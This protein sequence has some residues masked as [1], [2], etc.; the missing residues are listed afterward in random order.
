MRHPK[1]RQERRGVREQ[2]INK[3]RKTQSRHWRG[4]F[5]Y[6][7][8]NPPPVQDYFYDEFIEYA[9]WLELTEDEKRIKR[10]EAFLDGKD[11]KSVEPEWIPAQLGRLAKWNLSCSCYSC[12]FEKSVI[13]R[14]RRRRKVSEETRKSVLSSARLEQRPHKPEVLGSSPRGRTKYINRTP[15]WVYD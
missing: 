8:D 12:Q 10:V 7:L 15:W 3:R 14:R 4:Y 2:Y 11:P 13:Q 5:R 9:Q 6:S 1:D